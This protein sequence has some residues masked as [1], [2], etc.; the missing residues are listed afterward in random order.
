MPCL[1][2]VLA[3]AVPRLVC[4]LLFLLTDWFAHIV[5]PPVLGILAFLFLPTT[6]LC[7]AAVQHFY[8]GVWGPWQIAGIVLAVL[9]DVGPLR[10]KRS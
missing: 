2:V 5:Q 4:V 9:I 3:L 8:G 10:R 1:L 6:L 7:Y